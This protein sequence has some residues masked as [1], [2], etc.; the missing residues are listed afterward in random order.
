MGVPSIKLAPGESWPPTMDFSARL[1]RGEIIT[2][3]TSVVITPVT[4]PPLVAGAPTFTDNQVQFNLSGGIDDERYTVT[5]T[6]VTTSGTRI[7]V[8]YVQLLDDGE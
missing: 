1:Y 2:G 6:V 8:G 3:V 5:V 7:G 4:V